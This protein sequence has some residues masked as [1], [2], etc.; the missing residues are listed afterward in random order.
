RWRIDNAMPLRKALRR[1]KSVPFTPIKV[2][3]DDIAFLQYTG[4]TTGVAKGA[5]LTHYNMLA[6][7]EQTNQWISASFREGQEIVIAPLP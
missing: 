6:N 3:Q 1:G 2:T 7:L 5:I 4:G